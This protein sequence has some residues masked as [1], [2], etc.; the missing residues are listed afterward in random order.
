M[1]REC[2][3]HSVTSLDSEDRSHSVKSPDSESRRPRSRPRVRL[4]LLSA[5]ALLYVFSV[6]WYRAPDAPLRIWLGLPDWVAVALLCYVAAAV[7]NALAWW[8]TDIRDDAMAPSGTKPPPAAP[9]DE[10]RT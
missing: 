8:L 9:A 3:T 2:Y 10:E 6:P 5:I 4:L 1:A 7:L